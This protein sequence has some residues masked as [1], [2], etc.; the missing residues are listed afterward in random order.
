MYNCMSATS[1]IF[2]VLFC[3]ALIILSHDDKTVSKLIL[4]LS[5]WRSRDSSAGVVTKIQVGRRRNGGS[6][7]E[8]TA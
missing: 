6:F 4:G 8:L 5:D 7:L 3:E 2:H 1:D